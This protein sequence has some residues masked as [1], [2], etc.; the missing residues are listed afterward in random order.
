[1]KFTSFELTGK[2]GKT[3]QGYCWTPG[4]LKKTRAVF[5]ILH[6]MA[7]HALRYQNFAEF[8]TS[9]GF[10]VYSMDLR[11]HGKTA[12]EIENLGIL[13]GP[14]GWDDI[15]S[16]LGLL[17]ERARQENSGLPV[18][19]FGHSLGTVLARQ[20]HINRGSE[21]SGLIL[22]GVI[23]PIGLLMP[24]AKLIAQIEILRSGEKGKSSLLHQI[25]FGSYNKSFSPARTDFDWLSRD[26]AQVD[27]YVNDPYCGAVF[28]SGFY[29]NLLKGIT[30][31]EKPGALA[32]VPKELPVYLF[33]G[34][35]DSV[36][37]FGKA[38]VQLENSYHLAGIKDITIKIYKGAR[39][40]CL[41]EINR[42]EVYQDLLDW[43]NTH[44]VH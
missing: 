10:A 27:A 36:G 7:E 35:K 8:L 37:N 24:A 5:I 41:N 4:L 22:S 29:K 19:L 3:V 44:I 18:V 13:D 26:T 21:F 15:L 32:K 38:I 16:D 12:G 1:M 20:F 40:E 25:N 23:K 9:E 39:H 31:I 6:G 11:G 2:D 34:E 30:Q 42:E 43:L 17:L 28:T 33:G 14:G